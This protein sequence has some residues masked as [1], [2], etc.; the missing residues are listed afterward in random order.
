MILQYVSSSGDIF[1][2]KATD[3]RARSANF[4]NYTW[5]AQTKQ[6]QYGDKVNRFDKTAAYY[7]CLLDVRGSIAQRK[8]TL[9]DLHE[10]FDKDIFRQT[11]GKIVHGDYYIQCY[12]TYSATSARDPFTDNEI[13]IYCPYPFWVKENVYT[14]MIRDD[15]GSDEFLGYDY[16]YNYDYS[17]GRS[18]QTIIDNPGAGPANY[19]LIMYGAC[20][21]PY[22]IIDSVIVG[23]HSIIGTGEYVTID[24]RDH[25]VIKTATNGTKTNLYNYRTKSSS[26][27]G[28]ISSGNHTITWPGTFGF[29]LTVFEER[30][31][32]LWK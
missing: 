3:L 25:T 16:G 6:Q 28:K 8:Q 7:T 23:V 18:G 31:E 5:F 22:I 29:D 24:T 9:N 30:S 20:N 27:F 2:F 13:Q 1:D 4:H 15:Q 32:P 19:K 11:P 12:I 10:A 17:S 26:I 21:N 14:C